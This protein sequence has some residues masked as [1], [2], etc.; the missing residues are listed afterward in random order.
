[1]KIRAKMVSAEIEIDL[2]NTEEKGTLNYVANRQNLES[3]IDKIKDS[4][5]KMETEIVNLNKAQKW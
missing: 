5:I 3:L 1:M 2:P 4:V